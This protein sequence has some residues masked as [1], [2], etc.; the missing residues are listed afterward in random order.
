MAATIFA[1]LNV[2]GNESS[3]FASSSYINNEA[4]F[5]LPTNTARSTNLSVVSYNNKNSGAPKEQPPSTPPL[6]LILHIGPPK[7][8]TTTIQCSL[9]ALEESSFFPNNVAIM[10]TE[11]CRPSKADQKTIQ[12]SQE[13][14]LGKG[15]ENTYDNILL[16]KSFLP[17]CFDNK[18]WD[19]TEPCWKTA[20]LK[21]IHEQGLQHNRSVI[22]SNEILG[23][24]WV[25][26]NNHSTGDDF[27]A[28]TFFQNLRKSL[29]PR[30]QV[31]IVVGYR[32]W[33]EW[34]ISY[35]S[36]QYN[37][38]F[39][40]PRKKRK[41]L[42][43]YFYNPRKRQSFTDQIVAFLAAGETVPGITI[44][45]LNMHNH[46]VD[47]T[48]SF[49]CQSMPTALNMCS[50]AMDNMTS[51]IL[52][53]RKNQS[54]AEDN[55]I[56]YSLIS[57]E[58]VRRGM[59]PSN[60]NRILALKQIRGF[61]QNMTRKSQTLPKACPSADFYSRVL[62]DSMQ[63]EERVFSHFYRND[64]LFQMDH[65]KKLHREAFEKDKHKLCTVNT[66]AVLENDEWKSFF[67]SLVATTT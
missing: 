27:V 7:T 3:P 57:Q 36:Y 11:S 66:T 46:D 60:M 37:N 10:E 39:N 43:E 34:T 30:Y 49:Y 61:H 55:S 2:M 22:A 31:I 63:K 28:K 20:Y 64:P 17:N 58:A 4:A 33:Y 16:G 54:P 1:I 29:G 6:Y 62:N 38:F 24:S 65:W 41:T 9:R 53:V 56:F 32:R 47:L 19:G 45:L 14:K 67:P 5:Y 40:K 44:K 35:Y 8:G 15:G 13:L 48:H 52:R 18:N 26:M 50:L 21:Y 25:K 51:S 42:E 23:G 12:V 59:V